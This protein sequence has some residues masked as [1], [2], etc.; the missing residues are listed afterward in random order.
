[1]E[2]FLVSLSAYC[3][4]PVSLHYIGSATTGPEP[5]LVRGQILF[6]LGGDAAYQEI[7]LRMLLSKTMG[8]TLAH[9][10][11]RLFGL[12]SPRRIPSP[13][14]I[15]SPVASPWLITSASG[16]ASSSYP[17]LS[18]SEGM[19]SG[20]LRVLCVGGRTRVRARRR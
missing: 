3:Y 15:L 18:S 9:C 10:P 8:R 5:A 2:A 13:R 6:D 20:P 14:W 19:K 12:G 1:M 16:W 4:P 7:A 17:Y 11:A